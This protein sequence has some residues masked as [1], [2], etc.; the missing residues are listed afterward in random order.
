MNL[1]ADENENYRN[2]FTNKHLM[3]YVRRYSYLFYKQSVYKQLAL[4]CQIAK[5]LSGLNPFSQSNN[6]DHSLR[7]SEVVPL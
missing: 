7:N 6:K 4:G 2:E 5:Q 3:W 1:Q